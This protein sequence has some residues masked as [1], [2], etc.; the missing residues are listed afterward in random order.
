MSWNTEFVP[1]GGDWGATI[2]DLMGRQ[3]ASGTARHSFQHADVFQPDS[4]KVPF[5]RSGAVRFLRRREGRVRAL[6]LHISEGY[7]PR[8]SVRITAAGAV[9]DC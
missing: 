2:T 9:R 8:L 3:G 4:D 1:Q 6:G 5:R 7:R